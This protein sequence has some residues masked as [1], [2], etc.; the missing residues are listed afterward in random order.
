VYGAET[1]SGSRRTIVFV[2]KPAQPVSP[3]QPSVAY[4]TNAQSVV[5]HLAARV[6]APTRSMDVAVI[7]E[8]RQGVLEMLGAHNQQPVQ[9]LGP[10]GPNK[11]FRD[12]VRLRGFDRR[13]YDSGA[14]SLKHRI[15]A[16]R[17][18]PIMIAD[19]KMNR[20]QSVAERPRDLPRM[21]RDP[22]GVGMGGASSQ[23][24]A[25]TA[26]FDEE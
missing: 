8:D 12:P 10:D 2:N 9:A 7:E 16:V 15:E 26:D 6:P 20:L 5:D 4:Q 11:V 1:R 21:L 23:V 19:Q 22:L 3:S 24:H 18:L 25:A 17:K 14:L 13:T